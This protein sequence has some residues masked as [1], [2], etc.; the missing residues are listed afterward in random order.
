MTTA[1]RTPFAPFD[2]REI[3][4]GRA[5]KAMRVARG[6]SIAEVAAKAGVAECTVMRVEQGKYSPRLQLLD[7]LAEI[8]N[9]PKP[10]ESLD[11]SIGLGRWRGWEPQVVTPFVAAGDRVGVVEV[12]TGSDL[13]VRFGDGSHS[14]VPIA[15]CRRNVEA[16]SW[17]REPETSAI[18]GWVR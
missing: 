12:D 11:E 7:A 17:Y 9:T 18:A 2:S 10:S 15:E 16:P 6:L 4:R 8:V 1:T 14:W 13:Y 5:L 3:P